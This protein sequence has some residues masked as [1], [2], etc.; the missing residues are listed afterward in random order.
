[1]GLVNDLLNNFEPEIES[2]TLIPSDGGRYEV[3]VNGQLIYSKLQT[4]RHAEPGEVVGL[5]QKYSK[6][7]L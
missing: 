5:V 6:R 1:V 4:G 3:S 2:V 7:K